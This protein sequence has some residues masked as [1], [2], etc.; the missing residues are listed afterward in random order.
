MEHGEQSKGCAIAIRRRTGIRDQPR[1][2]GERSCDIT[3]VDCVV[4]CPWHGRPLIAPE[5]CDVIGCHGRTLTER[6]FQRPDEAHDPTAVL[7]EEVLDRRL[8][9]PIE[10]QRARLELIAQPVA[11]TLAF[12]CRGLENFSTSEFGRLLERFGQRRHAIDLRLD[13][14]LPNKHEVGGLERL[15]EQLDD[16][17]VVVLAGEPAEMTADD[18][19]PLREEW[20]GSGSVEHLGRLP[21]AVVVAVVGL[22]EQLEHEAAVA[23]ADKLLNGGADRL[24]DKDRVVANDQAENHPQPTSGRA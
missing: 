7:A 8:R 9:A 22:G 23:V 4:E 20:W 19:T 18:D 11:A 16:R 5:G 15:T 21:I 24:T 17:A 2:Q 10:V 1:Q 6:T 13:A 3:L 14:S 12:R